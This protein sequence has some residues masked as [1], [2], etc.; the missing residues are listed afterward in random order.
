[1]SNENNEF[2]KQH[3]QWVADQLGITDLPK[4]ILL[5]EPEDKTFG[6][7]SPDEKTIRLVTGGRH[8]VDVLR[9]LAHELTHHRQNL[10]DN[11]PPGAGETG[12]EQENEANSE[13]GIVLRDF[14]QE[15]PEYLG[16]DESRNMSTINE[17]GG[18]PVYYFAYGMLTD[19]NNMPGAVPVGPAELR[20]FKIEL[21]RYANIIEAAGS[22]VIGALWE[23][24]PDALSDL[25]KVEGVPTLYNRKQFPVYCDGQRY[26][27]YAYTMTPDAREAL[28][29]TK[30]TKKYLASIRRGYRN[31]SLPI[32]QLQPDEI[33]EAAMNPSA[34]G[35]VIE[36][37]T[38]KGVLVGFEF[39]VLVPQATI[40]TAAAEP[41]DPKDLIDAIL[42]NS[43]EFSTAEF[44][45]MFKFKQP[46]TINRKQANS[47]KELVEL[48][49]APN[50]NK[51]KVLYEKL[52]DDTK[53][54]IL[55]YW[56][57]RRKA[58]NEENTPSNFCRAIAHLYASTVERWGSVSPEFK[59]LRLKPADKEVLT[60]IR[61]IA[62]N[63]SEDDS[64]LADAFSKLRLT[65]PAKFIAAFDFDLPMVTKMAKNRGI[66]PEDRYED[67]WSDYDYGGAVKVLKPAIEQTFGKTNVFS[68]YHERAKNMTDWYIEP[69]GSLEADKSKDG[70]AE[71][72]SPPMP[73]KTAIESLK[74]FFA[75]A[76]SKQLYTNSTTG[77]HI[78]V[79]IPATIDV[80]KLAMFVG[81]QYV[82][83][84]F[85]RENNEYATSVL[86]DL[87]GQADVGVKK[88]TGELNLKALQQ[89][90]KS[91]THDHTASISNN[92][93]YISFRHAGGNYLQNPEGVLNVVGRFVH[94]MVIASDPEAYKQDYLKK[95]TAFV[96]QHAAVA[97]TASRGIPA[98]AS[99]AISRLKKEGIPVAKIYTTYDSYSRQINK[100]LGF[101]NLDG[102]GETSNA[103]DKS[104]QEFTKLVNA[105]KVSDKRA[106]LRNYDG[107]YIIYPTSVQTL[108]YM[109]GLMAK[110]NQI[111]PGLKYAIVFETVPLT[112]NAYGRFADDAK[113]EI[114]DDLQSIISQP[115]PRRRA[116]RV[117]EDEYIDEHSDYVRDETYTEEDLRKIKLAAR[118]VE[119]YAKKNGIEFKFT[120]HFFD[121]IMLKRGLGFID[122][123]MVMSTAAAIFKRGLVFFNDKPAGTSFAFRDQQTDMAFEVLKI[124]ENSY[125]VRSGIRT[126][127]W[128]GT[129]PEVLV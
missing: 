123:K 26:E 14:S 107:S 112:S 2:I 28:A 65:D 113:Y 114:L 73:A 38:E 83:Q 97:P 42:E 13:A 126:D 115:K 95:L 77:L 71:V 88:R 59:L 21:L 61:A 82:L 20:N 79:S 68:S 11:L 53:N 55:G 62:R 89:L 116:S 102:F 43:Y 120:K 91:I 121:Q 19:P 117:R 56:K 6:Q 58:W 27:A 22:K 25:D 31:F 60:Q 5:D 74:K 125:I 64:T 110:G 12:T 54:K 86:R 111:D 128:K 124:A 44:D 32:E 4:I 30:P 9:T 51:V 50:V 106:V 39:E 109:Y 84:Q 66:E 99:A 81:D 3:I 23:I 119:D 35:Q 67:R 105:S 45:K 94:S 48:S 72:V 57:W 1:M 129:S 37:G 103:S 18:L 127:K 33:D 29:D 46:L 85:G 34:Y 69:D 24:H 87:Q 108:T 7:Y 16:L 8:P 78:N 17:A 76:Q 98:G 41:S 80:L 47:F 118:S 90:A 36:T 101:G 15:N 10:E 100:A 49:T 52:T 40:K 93:K 63:I 96:G 122:Y 104:F 92:G 75:L 70:T